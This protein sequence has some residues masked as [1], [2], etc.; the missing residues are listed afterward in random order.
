M[1]TGQ[2]P[3]THL[4]Y[5]LFVVFVCLNFVFPRNEIFKHFQRIKDMTLKINKQFAWGESIGD[6]GTFIRRERERERRTYN[7]LNGAIIIAL[8]QWLC[9]LLI[10]SNKETSQWLRQFMNSWTTV[11]LNSNAM[12]TWKQQ[13]N[14]V[15]LNADFQVHIYQDP[16]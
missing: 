14:T 7:R 12:V 3:C 15:H 11:P 10:D 8:M 5:L 4:F 9:Y 6:T 16:P 1:P 13:K 2:W